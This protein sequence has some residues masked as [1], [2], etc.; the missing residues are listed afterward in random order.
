VLTRDGPRGI[1]MPRKINH[2]KYFVHDSSI[3]DRVGLAAAFPMGD[4]GSKDR[5]RTRFNPKIAFE[6]A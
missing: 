3:P 4:G 6:D 5:I 1:A 2:W